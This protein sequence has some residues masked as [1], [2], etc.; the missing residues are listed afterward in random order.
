MDAN[1]I[2]KRAVAYA[3]KDGARFNAAR[4]LEHHESHVHKCLVVKLQKKL[5]TSRSNF[6]ITEEQPKENMEFTKVKLYTFKIF[7]KF[8]FPTI[9]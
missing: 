8:R 3:K 1:K 6:D 5:S 4:V 7:N 2:E 9:C